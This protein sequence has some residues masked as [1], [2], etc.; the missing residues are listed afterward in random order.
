MIRFNEYEWK[1]H[2]FIVFLIFLL[3]GIAFFY[4]YGEDVFYQFLGGDVGVGREKYINDEYRFSVFY[5]FQ[6]R[7]WQERGDDSVGV[8]FAREHETPSHIKR[9]PI[10]FIEKGNRVSYSTAVKERKGI[11]IL[12]ERNITVGDAIFAKQIVSRL[13]DGR[14]GAKLVETVFSSSGQVFI[15][16]Q[17]Y[18][19]RVDPAYPLLVKTFQ[20]E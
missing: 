2:F 19:E 16:W 18:D 4:V 7:V 5:P 9:S 13:A 6:Y 8:Y 15:V 20:F 14:A 11:Q 1:K 3:C 17:N 12:T 10:I